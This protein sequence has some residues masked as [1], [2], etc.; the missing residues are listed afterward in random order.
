MQCFLYKG[1]PWDQS[2]IAVAISSWFLSIPVCPYE[3]F[4]VPYLHEGVLGYLEVVCDLPKAAVATGLDGVKCLDLVMKLLKA[5]VDVR[6][7]YN[8]N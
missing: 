8:G 2:G 5:D 4:V 6:C 3:V 7:H 1:Y